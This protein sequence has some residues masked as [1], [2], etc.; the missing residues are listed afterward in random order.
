MVLDLNYQR[1]NL[2]KISKRIY[3]K[4]QYNTDG[5]LCLPRFESADLMHHWGQE[6]SLLFKVILATSPPKPVWTIAGY[7]TQFALTGLEDFSK[8]SRKKLVILV[9]NKNIIF[10]YVK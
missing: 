9:R 1:D 7:S 6:I 3:I 10:Q 4:Q 8:I 5:N 2:V